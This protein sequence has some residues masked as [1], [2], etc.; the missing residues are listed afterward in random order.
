MV[1]IQCSDEPNTGH[2]QMVVQPLTKSA[3]GYIHIHFWIG[4]ES[5]QD[6]AGVAAIKT[7]HLDDYLGGYPIQHREVEGYE[8]KQFLSYFRNGIRYF[9]LITK[10]L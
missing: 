6:E 5:S 10:K 3:H 9:F 4:S 1:E 7:V 2:S 8:S